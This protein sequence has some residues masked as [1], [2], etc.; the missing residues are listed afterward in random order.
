MHSAEFRL[1][2]RTLYIVPSR[3][4]ALW[5]VAAALLLLVSIQTASN[6]TLLLAFVMFGLM[7]L[8]MFLTHDSLQG[9]VLRCGQPPPCFA[10]EQ[11]SYP[12]LLESQC[13]RPPV[14]LHLRHGQ[15]VLCER[16]AVGVTPI[17]LSWRPNRRGFQLPPQLQ[18]ETIAP[19]GL[20]ICWSRWTP[21]RPQLIW[22][23]RRP[24]P[25]R[26]QRPSRGGDG[27]D[28]WQDLRPVR[29]G[30]RPSLV[31]WTGAAKGR[32]LQAKVFR[33]PDHLEWILEPASGIDHERAR[34]HLA[35]RICQLHQR[36][37]FYG[38]HLQAKK[39]APGRGLRHRDACLEALATA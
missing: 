15:E 36:G 12:L 17:S 24:G 29:E 21:P 4:G 25:V 14:R 3:F 10:G 28:E 30:E 8:A 20:F 37:E 18:I 35:D 11:A 13:V 22:P 39:I 1:G 38:L 31:D 33:D 19:L 7:L 26:E 5:V 32:P 34:E 23:R 6:S 16:L 2:L 27:L 9:L